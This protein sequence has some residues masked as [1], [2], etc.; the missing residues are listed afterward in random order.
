MYMYMYLAN[1]DH[2]EEDAIG[3]V[4]GSGLSTILHI[5]VSKTEVEAWGHAHIWVV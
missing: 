3:L 5:V 1:G 4:E 2:L